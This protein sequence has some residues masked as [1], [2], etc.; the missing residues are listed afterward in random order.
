MSSQRQDRRQEEKD[1][2]T[3][4]TGLKRDIKSMK[5]TLVVVVAWKDKC[6]EARK[7]EA[8]RFLLLQQVLHQQVHT[9][10][11]YKQNIS[12]PLCAADVGVTKSSCE[13]W[14]VCKITKDAVMLLFL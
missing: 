6:E 9:L 2:K 12:C 3:K 5:A 14:E 8:S 13:Y 11:N 10:Q 7:K 4:E 1:T